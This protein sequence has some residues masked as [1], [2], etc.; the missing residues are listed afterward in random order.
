M[1]EL[2]KETEPDDGYVKYEK[3]IDKMLGLN[4]GWLRDKFCILVMN[5]LDKVDLG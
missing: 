1:E 5:L 2:I 4:Q 3:F